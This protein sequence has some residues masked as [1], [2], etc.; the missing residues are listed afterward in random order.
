M[1]TD[2]LVLKA[3]VRQVFG[4]ACR[5]LRRNGQIPAVLYGH[6]LKAKPLQLDEKSLKTVLAKAGESSLID[7]IVDET[8]KPLAVLVKDTVFDP[9]DE[10]IVHVDFYK[11]NLKEK[12]TTEVPL[13][14]IGNSEAVTTASGTL[15]KTIDKIKV[16]CLP[17]DLPSNLEIDISA[18]K[19]FDDLIY[20]KDIKKLKGINIL[21]ALEE[22]VASVQPPRSEAELAA[23]EETV[24]ED[25]A[26]VEGVKT[27]TEDNKEPAEDSGQQTSLNS[28]QSPAEK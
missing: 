20:I 2:N 27:E 15:I 25:V 21:A 9:I 7:L 13:V 23:L 3:K 14:F 22:V 19:T 18:L 28:D 11:V 6:K 26:A 5:S 17:L 1:T 10:S 4:K 24:K 8:S 12:I 16:E